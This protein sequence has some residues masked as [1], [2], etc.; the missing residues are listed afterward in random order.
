MLKMAIPPEANLSL[1]W[2]FMGNCVLFLHYLLVLLRTTNDAVLITTTTHAV[3][4]LAFVLINFLT[5][6]VLYSRRQQQKAI[7][8]QSAFLGLVFGSGTILSLGHLPLAGFGWYLCV[9]SFFH[10][11]EFI[12]TALYQYPSLT[13]ESFLLNHSFAYAIA[14]FSSWIEFFIE[15]YLIPTAIKFWPIMVFGLSLCVMG[16][17]MRKVAMLTAGRSFNHYIQVTKEEDHH[18]IT[19]GIYAWS[20]HPSYVGWFYWSVGTQILLCNPICLVAYTVASWRF[21]K[22]RVEDEEITLLHFFGEDYLNYQKKVGTKL[23]F[24][25]GYRLEL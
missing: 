12:F 14:A 2:F 18:L 24:I 6:W 20:R 4:L 7:S 11:A 16:E 5:I 9:L 1:R 10:F 21:F 22:E 15:L 8:L 17:V 13:V 19:H 25:K 3:L 23:P